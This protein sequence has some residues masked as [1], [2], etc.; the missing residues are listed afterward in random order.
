MKKTKIV[1]LFFTF[2]TFIL[3]T[4]CKTKKQKF[5]SLKENKVIYTY[6]ISGKIK[7]INNF[8]EIEEVIFE[9]ENK[10][11]SKI[12]ILKSESKRF[13]FLI[14]NNYKVKTNQL[15]KIDTKSKKMIVNG[16]EII[17]SPNLAIEN[18]IIFYNQKFCETYIEIYE[19]LELID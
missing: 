9:Q 19:G 10:T 5:E 14:G 1:I 18:C 15:L 13:N 8:K 16:K 3:L 17:I 6:I 12:L 11:L 4:N 7:S 2:F